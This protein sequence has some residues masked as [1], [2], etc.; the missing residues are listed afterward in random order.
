MTTSTASGPVLHRG[1]GKDLHVKSK[2]QMLWG[3]G[4]PHGPRLGKS[5]Q[6][7]PLCASERHT[8]NSGSELGTPFLHSQP[9]TSHLLRPCY[10]RGRGRNPTFFPHSFVCWRPGQPGVHYTAL[11]G[12]ECLKAAFLPQAPGYLNIDTEHHPLPPYTH[13]ANAT[14]ALPFLSSSVS[15]ASHP[16]THKGFG[17]I[18]FEYTVPLSLQ[19]TLI[20]GWAPAQLNGY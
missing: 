17:D 20:N 18:S 2:P 11:V 9:R 12:L 10:H 19:F 14:N 8:E 7:S 15:V 3:R 4:K 16:P 5:F 1:L 13:P 6:V